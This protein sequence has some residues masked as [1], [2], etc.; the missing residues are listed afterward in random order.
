[1][2]HGAEALD[3]HEGLEAHLL[4]ELGPHLVVGDDDAGV[5]QAGQVKGLAQGG[6][7][8]AVVGK[9]FAQGGIHNVFVSG[10]DQIVVDLVGHHHDAV[11]V[12]DLAHPAQLLLR[13]DAAG[14]ILGGAE[15]EQLGLLGLLT[16]VVEIHGIVA[17]LV[18]H[19]AVFQHLAAGVYG[20]AG[21]V[22]VVGGLDQDAVAGL[23][24]G[25]DGVIEGGNHLL[26]GDD[27]VGLNVPIVTGFHPLAAG[28]PKAVGQAVVAQHAEVRLGFDCVNNAGGGAE[29]HVG[30]R[31]GNDTLGGLIALGVLHD[32]VLS[33]A[34]DG[35]I[36]V[37]NRFKIVFHRAFSFSKSIYG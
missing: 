33:G 4:L 17:L 34:A 3:V 26:E 8:Y 30:H 2:G 18:R 37:N 32:A 6:A 13:P 22:M 28:L 16:E 35:R 21:E 10:L 7:D 20:S 36:A 15:E 12:A 27:T 9:L 23:G 11:L 31:Q 5:A 25:P 24:K 1:M 14:R 19:Q 29:L